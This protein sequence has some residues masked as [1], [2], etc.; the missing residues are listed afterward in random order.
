[1]M[2]AIEI[3]KKNKVYYR[4]NQG[5]NRG[6]IESFNYLNSWVLRNIIK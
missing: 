3:Y 6:L 1:M 5:K 2:Y 4:N